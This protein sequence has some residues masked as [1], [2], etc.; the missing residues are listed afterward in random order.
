MRSGETQV[1]T[2]V[3]KLHKLIDDLEERPERI[4]DRG[5]GKTTLHIHQLAGQIQVGT[6]DRGLVKIKYFRDWRWLYPM[7]SEIFSEQGIKVFSIKAQPHPMM[8][9]QYQGRHI[10][11]HFFIEEDYKNLSRGFTNSF[12][13]NLIDY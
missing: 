1:S 6:Y 3:D 12:E 8:D 4:F 9:I 10:R 7:I 5:N 11:L 2:D 13:F